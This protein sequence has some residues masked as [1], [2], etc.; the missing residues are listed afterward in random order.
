MAG[1]R[2]SFDSRL[3]INNTFFIPNSRFL[4]FRR[5]PG[6]AKRRQTKVFQTIFFSDVFFLDDRRYALR[7]GVIGDYLICVRGAAVGQNGSLADSCIVVATS[8]E[9]MALASAIC[10]PCIVAP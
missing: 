6:P 4:L 8:V 1:P 2:T 9:P 5:V 10:V 3:S 7:K